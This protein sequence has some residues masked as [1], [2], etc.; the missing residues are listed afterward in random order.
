M[1]VAC[2]ERGGAA[3]AGCGTGAARS[4]EFCHDSFAFACWASLEG[5]LFR[6]GLSTSAVDGIA[7]SV[8]KGG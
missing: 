2:L 3:D 6:E 1:W 4:P 5:S 7:V 8:L